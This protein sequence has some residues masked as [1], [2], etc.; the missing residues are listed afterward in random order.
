MELFIPTKIYKD[1][2]YG[3]G[4]GKTEM[5]RTIVISLIGLVIGLIT[6]LTIFNSDFQTILMSTVIV[7]V[8]F[9]VVGFFVS[10]RNSIN[11]SVYHYLSIMINFLKYQK[12]YKY[13]KLKEWY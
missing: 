8:V 10:I 9:A 2:K 4:F 11:L 5:R 13:K 12:L 7:G 3:K 6:G 1:N